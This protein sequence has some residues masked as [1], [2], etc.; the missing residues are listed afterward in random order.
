MDMITAIFAA[1]KAKNDLIANGQI[2]SSEATTKVLVNLTAHPNIG[3]DWLE[4]T[5]FKPPHGKAYFVTTDSG[6]FPVVAEKRYDETDG[7]FY[8][9]FDAGNFIYQEQYY[10]DAQEYPDYIY[11][12][13]YN[14]GNTFIVSEVE[15][16]V[17]PIDPK[18][19]SSEVA[20]VDTA[21]V[22]QTI[23]VKE[24]DENGKP[25]EWEAVDMPSGGGS[26]GGLPVIE[27]TTRIQTG[28]TLTEEESA[29]LY[30]AV[31]SKSPV[32]IKAVTNVNNY[33]N[34]RYIVLNY[35]G[36]GSYAN[37]YTANVD[38][39]EIVFETDGSTPVWSVTAEKAALFPV[40]SNCPLNLSDGTHTLDATNS[41]K[42]KDAYYTGLPIVVKGE[43]STEDPETR[44]P[45]T[46]NYAILFQV[47]FYEQKLYAQYGD[48][49]ITIG[50]IETVGSRDYEYP[51]TVTT[52]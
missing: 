34:E 15:E 36:N 12:E 28:A 47:D 44:E 31:E 45:I 38:G 39:G 52:V 26:G 32:V 2:G 5:S 30:A 50:K 29:A 21:S 46:F 43:Y 51:Y 27:F 8:Q 3:F 20:K 42:I 49:R 13:D 18:Y 33:L 24:V 14:G 40:V 23:V 41:D 37:R 17:H 25:T 16:T 35:T 9:L 10:E 19:L 1:N 11:I 6:T 4:V 48:K 22:G 7:Y